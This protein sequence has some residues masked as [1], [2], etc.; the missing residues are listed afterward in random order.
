M[1]GD[2]RSAKL[3]P[4]GRLAPPI[5]G[6]VITNNDPNFWRAFAILIATFWSSLSRR[7]FRLSGGT[8]GRAIRFFE[9]P[10]KRKRDCGKFWTD[11][12]ADCNSAAG[13]A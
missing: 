1:E 2:S 11:P 12:N 7:Y 3:R 9:L 6:L 10:W 5:F 4:Y 13:I 8:A